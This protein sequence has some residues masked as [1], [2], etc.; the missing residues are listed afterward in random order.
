[1]LLVVKRDGEIVEFRLE[2]ITMAIKK[3]FKATNKFYT[4]DIVELLSIR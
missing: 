1:M 2:K 4:D 3:A